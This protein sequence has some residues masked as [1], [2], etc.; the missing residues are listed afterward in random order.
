MNKNEMKPVDRVYAAFYHEEPDLIPFLDGLSTAESEDKFLG[1]TLNSITDPKKRALHYVKF[2]GNDIVLVAWALDVGPSEMYPS[3]VS[4]ENF[5]IYYGPFGSIH[6]DRRKP[7]FRKILHSPIKRYEDIDRVELPDLERRKEWILKQKDYVEWWSKQNYFTLVCHLGPFESSWYYLRG[8]ENTFKDVIRAPSLVKKMIELA[9]EPQIEMTKIFIEEF[10][11]NGVWVGDD[12]GTTDTLFFSPEKYREIFKPY[13][14]RIVDEYHRYGVQVIL[15]SH[16]NISGIF[17]DLVDVGFDAID[18]LDPDDNIDLKKIKQEFGD[19]LVLKGG[20]SKYI[21]TMSKPAI[22]K[23]VEDR[24]ETAA[25]GGGY[26]F[27]SAGGLPHTMSKENLLYYLAVSH[28]L[29]QY[30]RHC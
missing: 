8:L 22:R 17:E 6:C 27:Q 7:F 28:K 11:V 2:F 26:I 10:G 21:G 19:K 23:H 20:I 9:L 4:D 1:K 3:L 13:H 25:P 12:L 30:S 16:G 5:S 29:R 18:P 24:I 14:K 15:H